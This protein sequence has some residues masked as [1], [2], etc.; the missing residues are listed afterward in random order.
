VGSSASII[1][2]VVFSSI[3]M[4]YIIYGRKQRKASALFSGIGLCAFPYF[5]S[6]VFISILI[7]IALMTLPYFIEY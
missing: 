7:G 6:N 1:S 4:G 3:G 2:A 5:I